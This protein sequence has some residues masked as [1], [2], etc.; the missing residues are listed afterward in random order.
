MQH[1]H[2]Q[3]APIHWTKTKE[4]DFLNLYSFIIFTKVKIFQ[5]LLIGEALGDCFNGLKVE[6]TCSNPGLCG[7]ELVLPNYVNSLFCD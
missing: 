6:P 1:F 5:T 3:D 7:H 4:Y 2:K